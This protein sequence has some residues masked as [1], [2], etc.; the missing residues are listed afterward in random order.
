MLALLIVTLFYL[1]L[2]VGRP[3]IERVTKFFL[4]F[5]SHSY[6]RPCHQLTRPALK[7][8]LK[9]VWRERKVCITFALANDR[10]GVAR[11]RVG[12]ERKTN[13]TK[14]SD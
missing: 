8:F 2:A 5:V 12:R 4:S 1:G 6:C 3:S 7:L 10:K 11:E 9:N 14:P 13:E